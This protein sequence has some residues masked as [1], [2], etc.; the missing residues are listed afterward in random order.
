V[1]DVVTTLELGE[2]WIGIS[3]EQRVQEPIDQSAIALEDGID[4]VV[5]VLELALERIGALLEDAVQ[6]SLSLELLASVG[7]LEIVAPGSAPLEADVQEVLDRSRTV[8]KRVGVVAVQ[9][10][11]LIDEV[12]VD[13]RRDLPGHNTMLTRW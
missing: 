13:R 2:L 6:L 12:L 5:R 4:D 8:L 3:I 7:G 9:P 11:D 10:I 1:L